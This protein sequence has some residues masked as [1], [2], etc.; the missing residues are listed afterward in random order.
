[1]EDDVN[2]PDFFTPHRE[3]L[4]S[5]C[6]QRDQTN[7]H[8]LDISP[9]LAMSLMQKAIRR[10][11]QEIA[12][13][14]AAT[15]LRDSP[16]RL[17]RRCGVTAFE[18]IGVADL[19][20]VAEVTAALAGKTYRAQFGGEWQ[21]ASTIVTRMARATKCRAADD[22]LTSAEGHPD[23]ESA[24]R[25]FWQMP[26]TELLHTALRTG[27]LA[28]RAIA[29]WYVL[30]TNPRTC[31]MRERRGEPHLAFEAMRRAGLSEPL[32]T[33]ASEG[34]RKLRDPLST[35]ILLLQPLR[36][37]EPA[38]IA[39]DP[40]VPET[41]IRGVPS[42]AYDVHTR[43]GRAA[44]Q[45]FLQGTSDTARWVR[46]H[47][48]TGSQ[49]KFLGSVVF[50]IEGGL[51]RSRLCWPTGDSLRELV[52]QGCDGRQGV[53]PEILKLMRCDLPALNEARAEVGTDVR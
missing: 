29:F 37:A 51:T 34:F 43:E 47:I 21:V 50:R 41:L 24:R 9:W 14:A 44:L 8:P 27:P 28:E 2:D 39:D 36:S 31:K 3:R 11:E 12:L 35:A 45:R 1:M 10:G 22:L 20:V 26:A 30:G 7:F 48:A 16:D 53:A 19:E 17:W 40:C 46:A 13:R 5:A 23:L 38:A 6:E 32:V 4:D 25:R 15:L 18:D 49:V 42:W 52:D 33:T